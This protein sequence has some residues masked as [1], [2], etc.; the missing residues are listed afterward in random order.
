M[1]KSFSKLVLN[2]DDLTTIINVVV[3]SIAG[4][5]FLLS[6]VSLLNKDYRDKH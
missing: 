6:I 5:D 4:V 2:Y 1:N 3:I